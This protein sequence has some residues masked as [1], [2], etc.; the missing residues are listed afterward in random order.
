MKGWM[1][2]LVLRV[3]SQGPGCVDGRGER[4]AVRGLRLDVALWKILLLRLGGG[5][6]GMGALTGT[7]AGLCDGTC[8]FHLP[9][10]G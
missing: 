5:G 10:L 8:L 9:P 3:R 7:A 2:W 6:R 4:R 1:R